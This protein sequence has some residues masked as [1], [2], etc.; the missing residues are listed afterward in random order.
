LQRQ[1]QDDA[2]SSYASM[3]KKEDGRIDWNRSAVEVHNQIRG[4]DPWPGAYTSL[5]GEL[6]KLAKTSPQ[7]AGCGT[8]GSVVSAD[9]GGVCIACGSGTLLIKELQLAGRKRLTAG[10]FLRGC[11]LKPGTVL[12]S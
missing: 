8:P 3:M 6:L 1:A 12:E 7:V 9:K 11:T 10:D 4:L 5:N 2:Q